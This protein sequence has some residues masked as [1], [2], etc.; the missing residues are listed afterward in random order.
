MSY[1]GPD[2]KVLDVSVLYK[3]LTS[4]LLP[5]LPPD[6]SMVQC[7]RREAPHCPGLSSSLSGCS[8]RHEA[9]FG[10]VLWGV[11]C[12]FKHCTFLP[13]LLFSALKTASK[14][15]IN[16]IS[17][18]PLLSVHVQQQQKQGLLLVRQSG[19]SLPSSALLDFKQHLGSI[20]GRVERRKNQL[21]ILANLYEFYGS[22]KTDPG[23]FPI[24]HLF[25][26]QERLREKGCDE[27]S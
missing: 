2:S 27:V 19:E 10:T 16:S 18:D 1:S 17:H 12:K 23:S 5:S 15:R 22:V 3:R 8:Q 7:G 24:L 11:S 20:L 9:E 6:Q 21:D 14:T 26:K 25:I 4:H 13:D